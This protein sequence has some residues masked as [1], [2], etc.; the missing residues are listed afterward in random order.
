MANTI[1]VA[2]IMLPRLA[3]IYPDLL[4]KFKRGLWVGAFAPTDGQTDII[5]GRIIAR[6]SV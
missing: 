3:K 2:M 1:V 6:L 4:G 5:F